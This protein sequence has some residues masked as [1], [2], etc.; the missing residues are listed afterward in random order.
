SDL[1]GL[2][3]SLLLEH[4]D[5]G[6]HVKDLERATGD[7]F[8]DSA[9]QMESIL[10]QIAVCRTNGKYFL[11]PGVEMETLNKMPSQSQSAPE[12][13]H[14]QGPEPRKSG[15]LSSPDPKG[16]VISTEE[17]DVSPV[18]TDED[19]EKIDILSI[20][21]EHSN[22]K[23]PSNNGEGT[24][25]N[26]DTGSGSEN[27][28]D[29]SESDSDTDSDSDD[30]GSDSGSRS[31]SKS[32][33]Q[34]SCSAS[35]TDNRSDASSSSK[36]ASD[37]DVDIV[38]R[39]DDKES[40]LHKLYD[41]G[42][43]SLK[44]PVDIGGYGRNDAFVSSAIRIVKGSPHEGDYAERQADLF[45][46]EE[47]EEA[48]EQMKYSGDHYAQDEGKMWGKNCLKDR[49]LELDTSYD[50]PDAPH[51]SS[52]MGE[53]KRQFDYMHVEEEKTGNRKRFNS[54]NSSHPVSGTLNSIFG[55][56]PYNSSPDSPIE[57]PERGTTNLTTN[58]T[59]Q[60]GRIN[61]GLQKLLNQPMIRMEEK[62]LKRVSSCST[63][64]TRHRCFI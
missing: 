46:S 38:T 21:P 42:V 4:H 7:A 39:D 52:S 27:E 51:Q 53:C 13:N 32:I 30:S 50:Q 41:S 9:W 64:V 5:R 24:G 8:P 29:S 37:E 57:S 19:V 6:M 33:S 16:A 36:Q 62:S 23:K 2:M 44:S 40:S 15:K 43:V 10:K 35:S 55:D 25:G 63:Q 20:S 60:N 12:I 3:M 54:K 49:E 22:E 18:Y 61:E 47:G 17:K 45:H 34:R 48:F 31:R 14:H 58:G 1:C 11:K 26:S 59:M 28:S 56:S